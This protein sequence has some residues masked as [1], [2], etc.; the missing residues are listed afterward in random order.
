MSLVRVFPTRLIFKAWDVAA[1][2]IAGFPI[3]LVGSQKP[4][5]RTWF[6]AGP[7]KKWMMFVVACLYSLPSKIDKYPHIGRTER[8]QRV[9]YTEATASNAPVGLI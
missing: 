9:Y 1:R 4:V 5:R 7:I 2:L 3:Q 6:G 8:T